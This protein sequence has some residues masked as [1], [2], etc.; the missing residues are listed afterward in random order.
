MSD[1]AV[2][3]TKVVEKQLQFVTVENSN[4]LSPVRS[5]TLSQYKPQSS[6]SIDGTFEQP[7]IFFDFQVR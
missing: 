5:A 1:E 4:D 6:N 3:V 7:E 2:I